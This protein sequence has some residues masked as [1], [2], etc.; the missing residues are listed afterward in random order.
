MSEDKNQ[1]DKDGDSGSL[2]T[3]FIVAY[4]VPAIINLIWNFFSKVVFGNYGFSL[5][6]ANWTEY[7]FGV[8]NEFYL[9]IW[10]WFLDLGYR[11]S[12]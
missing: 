7:S 10:R 8:V 11:L 4:L 1:A 2:I 5:F 6:R 9:N 12:H 3:I